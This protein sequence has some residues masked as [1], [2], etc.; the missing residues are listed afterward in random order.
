MKSLIII[1]VCAVVVVVGGV[2][3]MDKSINNMLLETHTDVVS[4]SSTLGVRN[5]TVNDK[6][7]LVYAED[8]VDE[9][10]LIEP[11]SYNNGQVTQ[12]WAYLQGSYNE[13]N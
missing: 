4:G 2:V 9:S 1:A 8:D 11:V 13:S 5:S 10:H 3:Y 6:Q 7:Y 12:H